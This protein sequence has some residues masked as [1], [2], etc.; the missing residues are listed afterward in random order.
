MT[1]RDHGVFEGANHYLAPD[2]GLL[3]GV[4]CRDSDR[5]L[6][7]LAV[8]QRNAVVDLQIALH[9]PISASWPLGLKSGL[10]E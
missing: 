7:E 9:T 5:Q 6:R 8:I 3:S 4:T 10:A 2:S 1:N